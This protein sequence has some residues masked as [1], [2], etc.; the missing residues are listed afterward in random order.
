M[1]YDLVFD[2]NVGPDYEG[3]LR[4]IDVD[5]LRKVG[6][7]IKNPPPPEAPPLSLGK[8]ATAS[9]SWSAEYGPNMAMDWYEDTR[10]SAAAN[11]RDG[12]LEVDLGAMST[13][14][15]VV[16]IQSHDRI[17]EYTVEWQDGK[18]WKELARGTTIEIGWNNTN[19]EKT[20]DFAPVKT[21][22]VRLNILKATEEPSIADF[23]IFAPVTK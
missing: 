9:S 3:K 2:L 5:V 10:W 18:T 19:G 11:A 15:R 12:W 16:I 7:L 8:T 23:L 1:K 21:R 13:I 6:N 20:I 14:G 17:R 22:R 4:A